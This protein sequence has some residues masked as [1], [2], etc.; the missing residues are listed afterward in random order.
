MFTDENLPLPCITILL[1]CNIQ[2][3]TL[4][5]F[6]FSPNNIISGY[7]RLGVEQFAHL[8]L[9]VGFLPPH[10]GQYH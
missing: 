5:F 8:P 3:Y 10:S 2:L 6:L 1:K 4:A 7:T 9:A